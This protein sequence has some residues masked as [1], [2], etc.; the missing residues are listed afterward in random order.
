MDKELVN[1]G[2]NLSSEIL[3]RIRQEI[4]LDFTPVVQIFIK[5][6]PMIGDSTSNAVRLAMAN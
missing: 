1:V 5:E 4:A 6:R 3:I 2:L